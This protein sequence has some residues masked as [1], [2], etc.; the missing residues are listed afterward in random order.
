MN[1]ASG[2]IPY[3]TDNQLIST[4]TKEGRLRSYLEAADF[5]LTGEDVRAIE[6]AGA[7]GR[8]KS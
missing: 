3:A 8:P 4:S 7:G 6:V 5:D 1:F 2:F